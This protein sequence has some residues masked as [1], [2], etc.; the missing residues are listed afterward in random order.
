MQK[1]FVERGHE[2]SAAVREDLGEALTTWFHERFPSYKISLL[3]DRQSS[4][5]FAAYA[6]LNPA[7]G[8]GWLR[9]AVESASP[10]ELLAFDAETDGSGFWRGRRQVVWLCDHLAQ[11]PDHFWQCEAILFRLGLHETEEKTSNNSRG[12][13]QRFFRPV[14]SWTAIPFEERI[15]HLVRMIGG[16]EVG[17]QPMVMG[18]ALEA[19]KEPSGKTIPPKVVG[20]RLAPEE[21]RPKTHQDIRRAR[22]EAA[23]SIIDAVKRLPADRVEVPRTTIIENLGIFLSL[24]CLEQLRNWLSPTELDEDTLRWLRIK[25]DSHLDFLRLRATGSDWLD[26]HPT[27]S[28]RTKA[29]AALVGVEAWRDSLKPEGL[30]SRIREVTG[31][32]RWEH[33]GSFE[34]D[35]E[36]QTAAI[37][38]HL[39]AE[40][41]KSP[42]VMDGLRE[43]FD[44]DKARSA[45]EL[46]SALAPKG[47]RHM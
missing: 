38:E 31:R 44:S 39:A 4:R 1:R 24:G 23:S 34:K 36:E 37:Y 25:I 8:L 21:W 47:L 5:V 29:S 42:E 41:V 22:A 3:L 18:A 33:E 12:V 13:W 45:F 35:R 15:R 6:E 9:R 27:D 17:V 2:C 30:E 43:W 14:F 11:F 26:V 16:A 32:E 46:G 10:E 28:Q 19:I 7:L 20:G 40:V